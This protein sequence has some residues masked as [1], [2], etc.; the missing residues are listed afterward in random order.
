MVTSTTPDQRPHPPSK[1]QTITAP[2]ALLSC[3][4]RYDIAYPRCHR[5]TSPANAPLLLKPPPPP[6]PGAASLNHQKHST[7]APLILPIPTHRS[8]TT[9]TP[10]TSELQ[11][12]P[13]Q[14]L[15]SRS[16]P[17]A[18][19]PAIFAPLASC[20]PP[21]P[22]DNMPSPRNS[23]LTAAPPSALSTCAVPPLTTSTHPAAT[24]GVPCATSARHP[25]TSCAR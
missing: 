13:W 6:P 18:A 11:H 7:R 25:A 12:H 19:K 22:S 17:Q 14:T 5:Q 2:R 24:V 1:C 15:D 8:R 16:A 10:S 21:P 3:H 4:C 9:T 23:H 20:S